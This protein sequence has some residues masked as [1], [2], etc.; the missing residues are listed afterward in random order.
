MEVKCRSLI[1]ERFYAV[2]Q[3]IFPNENFV[4]I[5]PV[6]LKNPETGKRLELDFYCRKLNLA[7]ELQG[8]QHYK[9]DNHFHKT[10]ED[11]MKQIERDEF[12]KETCNE[13]GIILACIPENGNFKEILTLIKNDIDKKNTKLLYDYVPKIDFV[14][15]GAYIDLTGKYCIC[16]STEIDNDKICDTCGK[17]RFIIKKICKTCNV[18]K[19]LSEFHKNYNVKDGYLNECKDCLN[20]KRK[21][22]YQL[23]YGKE[24]EFFSAK[25]TF[26]GE[27]NEYNRKLLLTEDPD[28]FQKLCD[29]Y[30]VNCAAYKLI[31]SE[32]LLKNS[33]VDQ[34][35]IIKKTCKTCNIEKPLSAFHKNGNVKDGRLNECKDCLN[36]KR[37][38]IYRKNKDKKA[39]S[40]IYDLNELSNL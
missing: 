8:Y 28:E 27:T 16:E 34:S 40:P 17:N 9:S 24:N 18:E 12:K 4:K 22:K 35:Q 5:R 29:E 25:Q 14:P 10:D 20:R 39:D 3:K 37:K 7:I 19:P 23:L 31:L 33:I 38:I 13:R 32:R 2:I 26:I 11:F 21:S 1:E 30:I 36:K 6:W 15:D